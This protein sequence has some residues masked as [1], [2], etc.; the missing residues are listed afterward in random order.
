M[1]VA[2]TLPIP[3]PIAACEWGG[4]GAGRGRLSG[5]VDGELRRKSPRGD[6]FNPKNYQFSL[7]RA[8]MLLLAV[9]WPK[10]VTAV[11]TLS[12]P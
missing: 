11:V 1:D 3:A 7:K 4:G 2:L 10:S 9:V 5:A 12:G 6:R 8:V